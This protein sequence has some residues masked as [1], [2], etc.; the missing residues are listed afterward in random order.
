MKNKLLLGI[1]IAAGLTATAQSSLESK[2]HTFRGKGKHK[3]DSYQE[4]LNPAKNIQ[5]RTDRKSVV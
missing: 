2:N 5:A 4:K 1:A 3:W